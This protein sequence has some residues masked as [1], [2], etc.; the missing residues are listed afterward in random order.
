VVAWDGGLPVGKAML[1]F[2]SHDEYSESARR[3]GCSEARDVAVVE[4]ARRRGIGSALIR[5][6]EEAARARGSARIGMSLAIGTGA[7]PGELL[8]ERLGYVRAH[9]PFITSTD[10][11]DDDGRA[12][13]VGA[14][15]MFLVKE[16]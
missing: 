8:Y 2:P 12:M 10:L 15:M 9:G 16:L 14:V 11:W 4:A 1:L 7:G 3:E 13:P 6:L 5:A